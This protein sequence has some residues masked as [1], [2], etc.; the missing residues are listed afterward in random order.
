MKRT[1][2]VEGYINI[3]QPVAAHF[4]HHGPASQHITV[5]PN[6]HKGKVKD[7]NI[8]IY[9]NDDNQYFKWPDYKQCYRH[10]TIQLGKQDE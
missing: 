4:P 1:I 9:F 8:F 6:M 10:G 3:A 7:T 5:Q 2:G